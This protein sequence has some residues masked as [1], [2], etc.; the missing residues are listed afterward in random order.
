MVRILRYFVTPRSMTPTLKMSIAWRWV[1]LTYSWPTSLRDITFPS[2]KRQ[3][4]SGSPPPWSK[5]WASKRPNL[6]FWF[7]LNS[8]SLPQMRGMSQHRLLCSQ[9]GLVSRHRGS[10]ILCMYS[11][12][13]P[14]LAVEL[15]PP[16]WIPWGVQAWVTLLNVKP[17]GLRMSFLS[18]LRTSQTFPKVRRLK[19]S[20]T[21]CVLRS[22]MVANEPTTKMRMTILSNRV[23]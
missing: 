4:V 19:R 15:C 10:T 7:S 16:L 3:G 17:K 14:D 9:L 6:R 18:F 5:R 11:R 13:S 22:D 23:N 8:W 1:I 2:T 12:A 21:F 20:C